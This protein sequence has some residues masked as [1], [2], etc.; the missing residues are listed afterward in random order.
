LWVLSILSIPGAKRARLAAVSNGFSPCTA[1][2]EMTRTY[3][4]IV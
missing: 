3:L 2:L 4:K 1:V